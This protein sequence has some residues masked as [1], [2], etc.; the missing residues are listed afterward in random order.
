[1]LRKV[2][3]TGQSWI[4]EAFCH[5]FCFL[6]FMQ[7]STPRV[8]PQPCGGW[9]YILQ[10]GFV[11]TVGEAFLGDY[12]LCSLSRGQ[13]LRTDGV[14]C[15]IRQRLVE[16][17]GPSSAVGPPR[18]LG[19]NL[20]SKHTLYEGH[21]C[22][23][24]CVGMGHTAVC[25]GMRGTAWCR[26]SGR[27]WGHGWCCRSCHKNQGPATTHVCIPVQSRALG[28]FHANLDITAT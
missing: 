16:G 17:L 19:R 21:K 23:T 4:V 5:W 8:L 25:V 2:L 7:A 22:P 3:S 6:F 27:C 13:S 28:C 20:G 9:L 11:S 24:A 10:G 1:M 12:L 18:S 15:W 26:G 14:V